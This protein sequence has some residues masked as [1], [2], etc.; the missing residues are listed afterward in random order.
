MLSAGS[1]SRAGNR[2]YI[3]LELDV[4][5]MRF[6]C[7]HGLAEWLDSRAPLESFTILLGHKSAS[8]CDLNINK[9]VA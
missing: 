6:C 7:H 2:G 9:M 4:H 1:S 8:S 3:I 5:S